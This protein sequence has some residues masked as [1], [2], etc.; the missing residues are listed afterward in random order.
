MHANFKVRPSWAAS[1]LIFQACQLRDF[2]VLDARATNLTWKVRNCKTHLCQVAP[3]SARRCN[4]C[5]I[6]PVSS[7]LLWPFSLKQHALPVLAHTQRCMLGLCRNKNQKT[8]NSRSISM[9]SPVEMSSILLCQFLS[10]WKSSYPWSILFH[11][12]RQSRR[13][14][15]KVLLGLSRTLTGAI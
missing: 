3:L 6:N 1:P 10:P 15:P 8:L 4:S 7:F 2:D 13:T 9:I 14:T 5:L 12:P 11:L